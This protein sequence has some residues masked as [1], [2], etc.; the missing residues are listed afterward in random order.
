MPVSKALAS[1]LVSCAA[2]AVWNDLGV[3]GRPFFYRFQGD[4]WI[5]FI[6]SPCSVSAVDV[7]LLSSPGGD[8]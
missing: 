3:F 7:L 4:V 5:S 8:P 6:T 1:F 2:K